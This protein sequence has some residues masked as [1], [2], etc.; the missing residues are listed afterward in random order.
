M[1]A[2]LT[3]IRYVTVLGTLVSSLTCMKAMTL[4]DCCHT[5]PHTPYL[6]QWWIG[7]T[8]KKYVVIFGGDW[9]SSGHTYIQ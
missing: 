5:I 6:L 2:V 3:R 8:H 7:D 4:S 9:D 1:V